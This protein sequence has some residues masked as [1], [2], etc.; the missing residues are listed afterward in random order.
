MHVSV[1]S[2]HMLS[3]PKGNSRQ[4]N[5]QDTSV[6]PSC[7]PMLQYLHITAT[8]ANLKAPK[9]RAVNV[10]RVEVEL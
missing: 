6:V 3:R 5:N 2:Q 1:R 8:S 4:Q 9:P 7:L 10:L